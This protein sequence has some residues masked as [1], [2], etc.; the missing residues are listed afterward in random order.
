MD[1]AILEQD[2]GRERFREDRAQRLAGLAS[3]SLWFKAA[4]EPSGGGEFLQ[5]EIEDSGGGFDIESLEARLSRLKV[6]EAV[7]RGRGLELVR[8]VCDTLRFDQDGRRVVAV[9]ALSRPA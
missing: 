4:V 1:P 3:G 8:S 2:N 5:V 6:S 9:I 7:R